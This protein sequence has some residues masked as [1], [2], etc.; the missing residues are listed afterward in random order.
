MA[1]AAIIS[2]IHLILWPQLNVVGSL[3]QHDAAD[4]D[5]ITQS[6]VDNEPITQP[7]SD[8]YSKQEHD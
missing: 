8:E 5:S 2:G 4:T 1:A 3:V 7:S 6:P